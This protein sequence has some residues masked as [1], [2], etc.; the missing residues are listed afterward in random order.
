MASI[1]AVNEVVR[2]SEDRAEATARLQQPPFGFSEWIADHVLDL[3]VGRQTLAGRRQLE[4]EADELR[5]IAAG[6]VEPP[7]EARVMNPPQE[8][9]QYVRFIVGP[10]EEHEVAGGALRLI[11]VD[12]YDGGI[13]VY[14]R[15]LQ[16]PSELGVWTARRVVGPEV[17]DDV[18]TAYHG[19]VGG[20]GGGASGE[21]Y[22]HVRYIPAPPDNATRF[23][24]VFA[25][26]EFSV[27]L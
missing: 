15:H 22:G 26:V 9:L 2:E 11:G 1:D 4:T 3:G 20:A 24:V 12:L 16:P 19:F 21:S 10:D 18:G 5:P 17:G 6:A 8:P 27:P 14:W 25:E 13:G 7:S 23:N